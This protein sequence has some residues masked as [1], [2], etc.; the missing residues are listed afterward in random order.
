MIG[1]GIIWVLSSLLTWV[2]INNV[3]VIAQNLLVR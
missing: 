1:L 2:V 3:S